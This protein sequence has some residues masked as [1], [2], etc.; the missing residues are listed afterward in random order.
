MATIRAGTTRDLWRPGDWVIL[1]IGFSRDRPSCGLLIPGEKPCCVQFGDARQRISRLVA[2][3]RRPIN[4]LIEAP[5]S[6]AFST[7][8]NPT[9]R[10]IERL[11]SQTRYWYSGLGCGVMVAALYLI[12]DLVTVRSRATVRLFEGFVSYKRKTRRSSH[13]RDVEALRKIVHQPKR[14]AGSI[15]PALSLPAAP[16]DLVRSAGDL[17]GFDFGIPIVIVA[18]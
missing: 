9:G 2:R 12:H 1:D 17:C 8:G 16:G 10:S 3:G 7:A 4:L 5:L 18:G 11:K 13:L 6:V 15:F 14:H